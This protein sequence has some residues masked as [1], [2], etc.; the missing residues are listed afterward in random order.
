MTQPAKKTYGESLQ[1]KISGEF[2]RNKLKLKNLE[3]RRNLYDKY[4]HVEK[5][6]AEKGVDLGK[7]RQHSAKVIT[8]GALTGTLLFAPPGITSNM[9]IATNI[10]QNLGS[11]QANLNL[12]QQETLTSQIKSILPDKVGPLE[13]SQEKNLEKVFKDTLDINTKANLE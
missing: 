7:I 9:P 2:M 1:E 13:R 4:P 5:F 12:P 6:F 8:T 10:V 3:A 11:M